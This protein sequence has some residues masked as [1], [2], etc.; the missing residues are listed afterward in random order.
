MTK[1]HCVILII[2]STLLLLLSGCVVVTTGLSIASFVVD[3]Y[4]KY[5]IEER[6][7]ELEYLLN[8]EK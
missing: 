7:E 6:L 8:D 2:L 1:R 5:K 3:R 4:E